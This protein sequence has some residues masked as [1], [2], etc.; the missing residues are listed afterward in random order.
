[1][2][3]SLFHVFFSIVFF[4]KIN[5]VVIILYEMPMVG[6]RCLL[7]SQR[8]FFF[9]F[10]SFLIVNKSVSCGSCVCVCLITGLEWVT[11]ERSMAHLCVCVCLIFFSTQSKSEL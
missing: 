1:M 4:Q 8:D 5:I 2:H 6:E 7:F 11:P 9:F 3:N 10:H